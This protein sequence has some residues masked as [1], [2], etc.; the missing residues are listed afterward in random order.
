MS[1][2]YM[3]VGRYGRHVHLIMVWMCLVVLTACS[4]SHMVSVV[5][6]AVAPS[7][8]PLQEEPG[9]PA[10]DVDEG[11]DGPVPSREKDRVLQDDSVPLKVEP[12]PPL[13]LKDVFFDYDRYVIRPEAIPVL[14]RNAKILLEG[15]PTRDVVIQGHCDERGTEEYNLILGERRAAAVKSFLK[16]L[17]VPAKRLYVLSFGKTQPSCFARTPDCFQQNRRAHFVLK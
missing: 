11:R 10:Q 9:F 13:V 14:Q 12:G 6:H 4:S 7:E 3:G 5:R 1:Q 15:Y 16:D 17:G 2:M 8:D